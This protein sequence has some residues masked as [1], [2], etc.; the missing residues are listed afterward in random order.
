MTMKRLFFAVFLVA[1]C[2]AVP[3]ATPTPAPTPTTAPTPTALATL[4]PIPTLAPTA[5]PAPTATIIAGTTAPTAAPS[6]VPSVSSNGL[7]IGTAKDSSGKDYLTAPNGKSL[8]VFDVDTPGVSNCGGPCASTW[9]ALKA[10]AGQTVTGPS[11]ATK[12]FTTIKGG[13]V[14]YGDRPLYFY[15][16]D[17]AAGDTNGDGIG[18]VW[19]LARP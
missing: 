10:G 7:V 3:A 9:P 19:H 12:P 13:Q 16:G 18:G 11:E 4:P 14:A 2:S 1:A 8:Y 6:A 17:S 15:S 5:T